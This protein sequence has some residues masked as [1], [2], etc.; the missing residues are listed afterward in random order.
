MVLRRV[1][2]SFIWMLYCTSYL[3]YLNAERKVRRGCD[4]SAELNCHIP[5]SLFVREGSTV[6]SLVV[7][8]VPGVVVVGREHVPGLETADEV[9]M[10]VDVHVVVDFHE[11]GT[12]A[13]AAGHVAG[14]GDHR[15]SSMLPTRA[16]TL[17]GLSGLTI[18]GA[19]GRVAIGVEGLVDGL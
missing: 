8:G 13:R 12:T 15:A 18:E 1:D 3:A 19:R 5:F 16:G 6:L 9:V 11:P 10:A 2:L 7:K 14:D 4:N 17:A